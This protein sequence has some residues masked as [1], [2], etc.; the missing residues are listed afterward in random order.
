MPR[1]GFLGGSR[2]RLY[3]KL[4]GKH[5]VHA[6]PDSGADRNVMDLQYA[7]SNNFE[8]TRR[9]GGQGTSS[10]RT[11]R[12]ARSTDKSKRNGHFYQGRRSH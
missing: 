5:N 3:G 11:A 2:Q 10:S 8:I 12:V 1:F 7:I 6:I 4:A 9:P